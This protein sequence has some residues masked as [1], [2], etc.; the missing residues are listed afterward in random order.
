MAELTKAAKKE[1]AAFLAKVKATAEK[2]A[3]DATD[4][5]DDYRW[6]VMEMA[7]DRGIRTV[8]E[9]VLREILDELGMP[10]VANGEKKPARSGVFTD[11]VGAGLAGI[12]AAFLAIIAGYQALLSEE[13][14]RAWQVI[15]RSV[16]VLFGA[17]VGLGIGVANGSKREGLYAASAGAATGL[18]IVLL[19]NMLVDLLLIPF[20]AIAIGLALCFHWKPRIEGTVSALLA[21]SLLG[22]A[23]LILAIYQH[24]GLLMSL[25]FME[26]YDDQ[27]TIMLI[28]WNAILFSAGGAFTGLGIAVARAVTHEG[29]LVRRDAIYLFWRRI[30]AFVFDVFLVAAAVLVIKALLPAMPPTHT[31]IG[32][33]L[34]YGAILNSDFGKGATLGKRIF[35]IVVRKAGG[36]GI[37]LPRAIL[38]AL[39]LYP[40]VSVTAGVLSMI[41]RME[42]DAAV[43]YNPVTDLFSLTLAAVIVGGF[44]FNRSTRR[45]V[46]DYAAGSE[47]VCV[48][49]EQ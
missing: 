7:D 38:R 5:T 12:I 20:V 32:L 2:A 42:S 40:P 30:A 41:V 10:E 36:G 6:H 45:S 8:D 19:N 44:L 27:W 23:G 49:R 1:L 3:V 22:T 46:H 15:Q 13:H 26:S 14:V 18:V 25:D 47:V 24:K 4:V 39:V 11:F 16:L 17:L 33:I 29:D 43:A 35:G 31:F 48:D 21:C 28:F 34:I 37:D 9:K